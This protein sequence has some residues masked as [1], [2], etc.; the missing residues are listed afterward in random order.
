M[1]LIILI[2]YT[3][4]TTYTFLGQMNIFVLVLCVHISENMYDRTTNIG[5][6]EHHTLCRFVIHYNKQLMNGCV[7]WNGN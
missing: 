6:V 1:I 7:I 5:T 3:V 4:Y 2:V